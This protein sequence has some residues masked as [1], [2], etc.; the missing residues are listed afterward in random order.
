MSVSSRLQSDFLCRQRVGSLRLLCSIA[1]RLELQMRRWYSVAAY[2]QGSLEPNVVL[3]CT[4]PPDYATA[5][6]D[7]KVK[8]VIASEGE[9]VGRLCWVKK[10]V[11]GMAQVGRRWQR[12]LFPHGS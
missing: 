12:T 11:Y 5:N 8:L 2:L 4:S 1:A 9:G 3:Y 7:G 6:V 10:P